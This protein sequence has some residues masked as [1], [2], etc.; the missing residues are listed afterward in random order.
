MSAEIQTIP[1]GQTST[2]TSLEEFLGSTVNVQNAIPSMQGVTRYMLVKTS[3]ATS[4]ANG[5]PVL[6]STILSRQVTG[7]AAGASAV[8]GTVAGLAALSPTFQAYSGTAL[9][10]T[11]TYF[12]V[13]VSGPAYSDG[14]TGA[15]T[16]GALL[17]TQADGKLG[18]TAA[19]AFGTDIAIA[20][21]TG[22]A[23]GTVVVVTLQ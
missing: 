7:A 8:R 17:T 16:A 2:S 11:N 1:I 18:T 3:N 13:A 4:I 19:A 23:A 5:R 22:T 21:G 12:W 20:T 9:A 6:W 15:G 10:A 14:A